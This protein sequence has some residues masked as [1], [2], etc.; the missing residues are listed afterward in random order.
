MPLALLAVTLLTGCGSSEKATT[1]G[2]SSSATSSTKGTNQASGSAG[3]TG[4]V[5]AGP[6]CPVQRQDQPCP[7]AP[8]QA[9]VEAVDGSGQSVAHTD[10]DAQGA[11]TLDLAPGEYTLRVVTNAAYPRCPDTPAVV[12]EGARTQIDITCDTGIR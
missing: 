4:H 7:T 2:S 8:V 10:S 3:V 5:T 6:T 12:T 11:F 9:R 1:N